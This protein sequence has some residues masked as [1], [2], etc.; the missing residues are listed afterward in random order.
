MA[1][2]LLLGR[3]GTPIP[4]PARLTVAVGAPMSLPRHDSPPEELVQQHLDRYIAEL[5]ALFERHKAAAGYKD[6]ELRIL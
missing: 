5:S 3:W 4:H 1:P 6:L 2:L